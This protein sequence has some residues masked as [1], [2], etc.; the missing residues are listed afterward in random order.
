MIGQEGQC[1]N[2]V[3]HEKTR[4]DL[5]I[6]LSAC[7][8]S[9][10]PPDVLKGWPDRLKDVGFERTPMEGLSLY[11]DRRTGLRPEVLQVTESVLKDILDYLHQSGYV[12]FAG[13]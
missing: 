11:I 2:G 6:R 7:L 9:V 8:G 5:Q 13:G 1:R 3:F 4:D 12:A 10:V